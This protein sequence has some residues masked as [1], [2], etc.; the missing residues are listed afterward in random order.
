MPVIAV[1][2]Q[3]R[4]VKYVGSRP[5]GCRKEAGLNLKAQLLHTRKFTS[6]QRGRRLSGTTIDTTNQ[7]TIAE[8]GKPLVGVP[9][10]NGIV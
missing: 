7:A 10:Q 8:S 5:G 1:T 2:P 3:E 6:L 4:I 9:P